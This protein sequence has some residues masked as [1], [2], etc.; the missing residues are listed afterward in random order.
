MHRLVRG[1]EAALVLSEY[2]GF[3]I[4]ALEAMAAGVP[5]IAADRSALPEV[6][7]YGGLLVDP[8]KPDEIIERILEL[9]RDATLRAETIRN[10]IRRAQENRWE[11]CVNR[12]C[13]A[14]EDFS[15]A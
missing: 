1:A 6:V 14:L 5:V 3:G 9:A 11:R 2:E 13:E 10:G 4:P 7:G 8:E 15:A 12:L